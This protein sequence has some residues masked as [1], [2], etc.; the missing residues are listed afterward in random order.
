ML[1]QFKQLYLTTCYSVNFQNQRLGH[2]YI[3][4]SQCKTITCPTTTACRPSKHFQTAVVHLSSLYW[5]P[6][7]LLKSQVKSI[8]FVVQC[9]KNL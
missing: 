2:L 5:I 4:T 7:E 1:K 3:R 6:K 9:L 8:L